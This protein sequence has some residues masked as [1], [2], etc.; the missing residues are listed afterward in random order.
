MDDKDKAILRKVQSELPIDEQPFAALGRELGMSEEEVLHR[1]AAMKK[2]GVIR[3]IGGNF[4]SSSLG[5]A[6]TLCGAKVP[7]DK[8][9]QF[10]EAVNAHHGV[11][12]NY[13]RTHEYNCW[14]TFIAPTMEDIDRKLAE[15]S[16]NTGV[17]DIC[18]MPSL[19]MFKIKVDF[20][21]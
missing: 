12:H 10:V 4:N 5:F 21:I 8:F 9:D 20:P 7:E 17:A 3:R 18:S 2:S 14:F 1:L 15:I 11:T 19:E 13:R 16:K 6:A